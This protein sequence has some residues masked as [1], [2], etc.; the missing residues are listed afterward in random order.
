MSEPRVRRVREY[1]SADPVAVARWKTLLDESLVDD[2]AFLSQFKI[3][4]EEGPEPVQFIYRPVQRELSNLQDEMEFV[5]ETFTE[6]HVPK[7]RK[8]GISRQSTSRYGFARIL[9]RSGYITIIIAQDNDAAL[10][11]FERLTELFDQVDWDALRELGYTKVES[12]KRS[13]VIRHPNGFK[14][15]VR[16]RTASKRGLGRGGTPNAIILTE[17]GNAWSKEAEASLPGLL[18]SQR[19]VKGNALI[20]ESTAGPEGNGF[21]KDCKRAKEKR[22]V[23]RLLFFESYRHDMNYKPV[24]GDGTSF[25]ADLGN[26]YYG[27]PHDE[28]DLLDRVR[29]YWKREGLEEPAARAKAIEFL[30]W[31]RDEIDGPCKGSVETFHRDQPTTFDEAFH[32]SG[33]PVFDVRVLRTWTARAEAKQRSGIAGIMLEREGGKVVFM[34]APNGPLRVYH[35]PQKDGVYCWGKDVAS[36]RRKQA[37]S[38]LE[39]DLTVI[40]MDDAYTGN[41]VAKFR[42]HIATPE[43]SR[44]LVLF[45]RWYNDADEMPAR[46]LVEL[47]GG[48]GDAVVNLV[49]EIEDGAWID[50]LMTSTVESHASTSVK[51][52]T[53]Y[54]FQASKQGKAILKATTEEFINSEL[55]KYDPD[56]RPD[57]ECPFDEDTLDELKLYSY[58]ERGGMEASSGHDDCVVAK[59]L[60]LYARSKL[61]AGGLVRARSDVKPKKVE[62]DVQRAL[63]EQ[64]ARIAEEARDEEEAAVLPGF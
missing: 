52:E 50:I 61:F 55:K 54:G 6:I 7:S 12:T 63:R 9:R 15:I 51:P 1:T 60:A 57:A 29:R 18:M 56:L 25:L 4:T 21:H 35:E 28:E 59:M 31:R 26:S 64:D 27:E 23:G 22:G 49:L 62:S 10:E 16:V 42:G 38:G 40:D 58:N 37:G 33:L 36:G 11:H 13:I 53:R 3:S 34:P 48:W 20:D 44:Q 8:H 17:R 43:G 41:T 14:S 32:G 39:A 2:E 24:A 45:A 46:G 47:G 19:R 5:E 30:A